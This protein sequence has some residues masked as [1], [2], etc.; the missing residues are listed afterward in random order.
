M[1]IALKLYKKEFEYSY[2][3]GVFPTLELLRARPSALLRVLASSLGDRN[4]GVGE[5]EEL[6]A[7]R[8]IPFEINDKAVERLAPKENAYTVG[9]FGKYSCELSPTD[10]HVVLVNPSDMGNLGT[11]ARSM[12]G[13]SIC[14]L[15]VVRPAADIFDPRVVRASM[16]GIFRLRFR[17]FDTFRQYSD[18][19]NYNLYP[20]MTGGNA[21]LGAVNFVAPFSLLFGNESAGLGEEFKNMGTGVS[22]KHSK[23]IDS[24]S[25]P[26]AVVVALYEVSRTKSSA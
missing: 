16:G 11:I 2:T 25:L 20:F 12:V 18:A 3:F 26:M 15:G 24:L 7:R 5:I 13:F 6:C 1:D 19:F 10:N 21:T 8:R 14:D 23:D 22:I 17:Y 4:K 9:I